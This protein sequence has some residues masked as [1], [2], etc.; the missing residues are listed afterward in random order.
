MAL[1]KNTVNF[2]VESFQI[3]KTT[4]AK[5]KKE[6]I[7]LTGFALPFDTTSRNGF[8]YRKESIIKT[9]KSM[10]GRPM[11][12][13]HNV[14]SVPIG[15]VEKINVTDKGME[16]VARLNPVTQEG[17]DV[18]NAIK[19]GLIE[20]VSIQ[21]MY[22]NAKLNEKTNTF[23]VDV[24]E[25]LELSVVTIP[26][27]AETTAM[28]HEKLKTSYKLKEQAV[29]DEEDEK[30]SESSSDND[31]MEE[32]Q[33]TLEEV[34]SMVKDLS[35]TFENTLADMENK[36]SALSATVDT[37]I[38][39]KQAEEEGEEETEESTDSDSEPEKE[40]EKET[41]E[42]SEDEDEEKE[43]TEETF[44]RATVMSTVPEEKT[45]K[46]SEKLLNFK[47]GN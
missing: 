42:E 12:F 40:E 17:K 36:I 6:G 39:E 19:N 46:S 3:E 11:F 14:E 38:E 26:G 13:N 2:S 1:A 24:Q 45:V 31:K 33:M 25:F 30:E 34:A 43:K 28:A 47:Y 10:E 20:N 23:E 41:T 27:F 37:L 29:E 22:E 35:S 15:K 16:Y 21:C 18:V 4:P 44:K 7:T 32:E 8:A 9:A 5:E